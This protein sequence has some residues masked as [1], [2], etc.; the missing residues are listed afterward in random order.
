HPKELADI[1]AG[2]A[3]TPS[4]PQGRRNRLAR[5]VPIYTVIA[6][7]LLVG[8]YFFVTYEETAIAVIPPAERVEVFVPLTPTP[9]PT[10]VPTKTPIPGGL[11]SWEG[12]VAELFQ[13]RCVICHNSAGKIG[14]LDLST[15]E[16]AL[17]GGNS[18]PGIVP[19]EPQNSQV[20]IVQQAGGHPGQ[21]GEEE[22]QQ[23]VEWIENGA[24]ER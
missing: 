7:V 21:L 10:P 23:L 8:I 1:K 2:V 19:G 9:L 3:R 11:A 6:A 16:S 13:T 12:G 20:I 15:Y 22:I 18:G 24:P 14:G 5:F 4:T 17:A